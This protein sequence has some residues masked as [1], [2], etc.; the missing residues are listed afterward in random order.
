M[1]ASFYLISP[2][3]GLPQAM[4]QNTAPQ[5]KNTPAQVRIVQLPAQEE[6]IL[7]SQQPPLLSAEQVY[8][9]RQSENLPDGN[10]SA[11]TFIP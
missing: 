10:L 11:P 6:L 5:I 3:K 7:D 2:E 4:N 9:Q 8:A 1:N